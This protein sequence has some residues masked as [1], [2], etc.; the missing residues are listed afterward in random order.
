MIDVFLFSVS[1]MSRRT[2]KKKENVYLVTKFEVHKTA[3]HIQGVSEK[4]VQESDGI[5]CA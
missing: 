2:Q 3:R 5:G 1:D 4:G